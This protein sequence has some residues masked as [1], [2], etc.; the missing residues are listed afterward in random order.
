[1]PTTTL[2]KFYFENLEVSQGLSKIENFQSNSGN[3][4][5]RFFD[6]N[7]II[8]G[9][10]V[11]AFCKTYT[12]QKNFPNFARNFTALP[13]GNYELHIL[14]TDLEEKKKNS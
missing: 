8:I 6:W 11:P 1:M 13:T 14:Q 10:N 5:L 2:Y 12:T 4:S 9:N 7:N 3:S